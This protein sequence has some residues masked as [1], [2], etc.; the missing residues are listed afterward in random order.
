MA[1]Y[2]A[3]G[4]NRDKIVIEDFASVSGP[5]LLVLTAS[6]HLLNSL[7]TKGDLYNFE[8]TLNQIKARNVQILICAKHDDLNEKRLAKDPHLRQHLIRANDYHYWLIAVLEKHFNDRGRSLFDEI[9]R[10]HN[11]QLWPSGDAEFHEKVIRLI[12]EGKFEEELDRIQSLEGTTYPK[13]RL[14]AGLETKIESILRDGTKGLEHRILFLYA[15]YSDKSPY[16]IERSLKMM[17]GTD[18]EDWKRFNL[19]RIQL[20]ALPE[21]FGSQQILRAFE[22]D[23]SL[24]LRMTEELLEKVLAHPPTP[25]VEKDCLLAI[26]SAASM[27][28]SGFGHSVFF[29]ALQVQGGSG[30]DGWDEVIESRANRD[31]AIKRGG[32]LLDKL[33]SQSTTID[34]VRDALDELMRWQRH[35]DVLK[36]LEGMD[37]SSNLVADTYY[38]YLARIFNEGNSESRKAARLQLQKIAWPVASTFI[39]LLHR[40]RIWLPKENSGASE[41]AINGTEVVIN[42][43]EALMFR[44]KRDGEYIPHSFLKTLAANEIYAERFGSLI[45]EWLF[46]PFVRHALEDIRILHELLFAH[47]WIIPS[48]L[49]ETS[50][51]KNTDLDTIYQIY[52]YQALSEG[53]DHVASTFRKNE[54]PLFGAMFLAEWS[55]AGGVVKDLKP[56]N[57]A[58][59]KALVV[60]WKAIDH[61]LTEGLAAIGR[62]FNRPRPAL[63]FAKRLRSKVRDLKTTILSTRSAAAQV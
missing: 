4:Q 15:N 61:A 24:Y 36:L 42:I 3:V 28:P 22:V 17:I 33:L 50:L 13:E 6:P 40:I 58:D 52:C 35:M 14:E 2:N 27:D 38:H 32:C 37:I 9:S 55:L 46:H 16:L 39:D 63:E 43:L 31:T 11:A 41:A 30:V 1:K 25:T 23:R 57:A 26:A 8:H 62:L 34:I 19:E 60:C 18:C 53:L 7:S 10:Q 59:Q 29:R 44:E 5:A 48:G 20:L 51:D 54:P 45:L 47:T 12:D 21:M 49:R 56:L